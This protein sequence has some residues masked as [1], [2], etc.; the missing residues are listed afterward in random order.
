M[1]Y[2]VSLPL[3]LNVLQAHRKQEEFPKGKIT[4]TTKITESSKQESKIWHQASPLSSDVHPRKAIHVN[5]DCISKDW[6][7]WF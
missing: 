2:K 7:I 1:L 6:E 5:N 3:F 4:T